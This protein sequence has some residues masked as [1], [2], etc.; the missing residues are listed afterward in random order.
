MQLSGTTYIGPAI[1]DP[2]LLERLGDEHRSF[3]ETTNGLVAFD[4]GLHIRGVCD[5]PA[6]HSLRRA[7]EGSEAY[8]RFYPE[9]TADD[10]P[11]AQD[12]FGDQFLLRDGFVIRLSAEDAEIIEL[13]LRFDAFIAAACEDP[14]EFL[15]LGLLEEFR[16]DGGELEPGMLL[17]VA[18]P[19]CSEEA[20]HGVSL[21][22]LPARDRFIYLVNL[23]HMIRQLPPRDSSMGRG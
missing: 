10:V 20:L 4:G 8:H 17:G 11:F 3:L 23:A 21:T 18:P 2:E 1:D 6:W 14:V 16:R 19:A 15:A 22:K 5:E 12:A 7:W 9:L 13:G